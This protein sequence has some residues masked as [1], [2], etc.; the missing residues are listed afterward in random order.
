MR[1]LVG[2]RLPNFTKKEKHLIKGSADFIAINYYSSQFARY[3]SNRT[4]INGFDNFDTLATS[5]GNLIFLKLHFN[6]WLSK[7]KRKLHNHIH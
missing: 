7:R 4:K 6:Y 3:E 2:N 5:E 1:K